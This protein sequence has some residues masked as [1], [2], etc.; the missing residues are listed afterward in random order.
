[1]GVGGVSAPNNINAWISGTTYRAAGAYRSDGV[2]AQTLF[3]GCYSES[4]QG[5]SQ[6]ASPTLSIGGGQGAPWRGPGSLVPVHISN[7]QGVLASSTAIGAINGPT[8]NGLILGNDRLEF[9]H[10]TNGTYTFEW[11]NGDLA[12]TIFRSGVASSW[13]FKLT[14]E[15]TTSPLGSRKLDF[16]NGFGLAGKKVQSGVSAPVAG[17]YAQGDMV[18]NPAPVAGGVPGWICVAAGTPGTWKAM[19]N[20]AA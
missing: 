15:A 9:R 11:F 13:A 18:W 1:M 6:G 2:N 3:T 19:A 4:G 7:Y 17:T 10:A 8:G 16:P 14:G 20:I 5:L 12:Y